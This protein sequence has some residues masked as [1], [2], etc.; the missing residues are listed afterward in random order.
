[1]SK[2]FDPTKPVETRDG[3]K[4]RILCTDR[5][6]DCGR[7]LV[8]LV[9]SENEGYEI[10]YR[11]GLDGQYDHSR[12]L[13]IDLVNIPVVRKM[14]AYQYKPE[15]KHPW[16]GTLCSTQ[17]LVDKQSCSK[18]TRQM[19]EFTYTDDVLTGVELIGP[20]IKAEE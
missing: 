13:G 7:S 3:R 11:F 8:A 12:Q 14:Y 10:V 6:D 5:I 4:A 19:L 2:I 20:L 15:N 16:V 1:M 18:A 17:G 9:L